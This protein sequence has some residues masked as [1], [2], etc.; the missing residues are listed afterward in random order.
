MLEKVW[1]KKKYSSTETKMVMSDACFIWLIVKIWA[2][3]ISSL[4]S[5]LTDIM[6]ISNYFNNWLFPLV[7]F[8]NNEK[9][10]QTVSGYS[11]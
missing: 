9:K 10:G 7:V 8:N 3:T 6:I 4:M 5:L 11:I 2:K 1:G